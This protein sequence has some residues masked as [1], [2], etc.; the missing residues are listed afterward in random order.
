MPLLVFAIEIKM[1]CYPGG[2]LFRLFVKVITLLNGRVSGS[3]VLNYNEDALKTP[4]DR[5]FDTEI[6][7]SFL[8]ANYIFKIVLSRSKLFSKI[9]QGEKIVLVVDG[10]ILQQGL[11]QSM[12][13]LDE[14][15]MSVREHGVKDISQADLV[16]LE[17][18]GNITVLS[19]DYSHKSTRRRRKPQLSHNP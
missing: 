10:K 8:F 11:K 3:E 19:K 16:V 4:R 14:L 5:K 13:S 12:M 6:E 7:S 2:P 18:D 1:Y 15:Q 9:V 17:V